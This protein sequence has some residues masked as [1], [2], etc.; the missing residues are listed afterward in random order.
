MTFKGD[1][2]LFNLHFRPLIESFQVINY[3]DGVSQIDLNNYV[4]WAVVVAQL[5]E[6]SFPI[7]EFLTNLNQ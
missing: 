3:D 6:R 4:I 1:L 5:V 7:P 2:F